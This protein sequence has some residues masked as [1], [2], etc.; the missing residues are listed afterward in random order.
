MSFLRPLPYQ[1]LL[2]EIGL[3]L[4]PGVQAYLVGGAVRDAILGRPTNDLDFSVSQNAIGLGRRVA[5]NLDGA[6]YALD[7]DRD[8]A[9]VI[10]YEPDG[11]RQILDFAGLRGVDINSDL[12]GRDFTLNAMALDLH[13]PP[14]LLDPLDG[15]NDMRSGLLRACSERAIVDDPLRILRGV[16]LASAY[17]LRIVP[18]TTQL[19]RQAVHLLPRVSVERVRDELVRTLNGPRQAVSL[20]LLDAFGVLPDILPEIANLK[21]VEQSPPHINDV[22]VHTVDVISKL[23]RV[24]S[25]LSLHH[26]PEVAAN[27]ALGF[28]SV[29]LGRYREQIYDQLN[30]SITTG[31]SQRSL[32]FMAALYHDTGKP[33]TFQ[34]DDSGRIRFFKHE[35]IGSKLVASRG[36][37]LRLSKDEVKYLENIVRNH[38]RPL[39]LTK[40]GNPPSRRAIYRF[41]R[42]TGQAGVDVCL[43]SLADTLATYG[44]KLPAELW[45]DQLS[46]VRNLLE[47]WFE[48]QEEA[49]APT[50]IIN[51]GDLIEHFGIAPGP[52]IGEL[53]NAIREAQATGQVTDRELALDFAKSWLETNGDIYGK[54]SS[55]EGV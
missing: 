23:E 35:V 32:L 10:L 27:W 3:I 26:D 46:V 31:R 1:D 44:P 41:F 18:E 45:A 17:D 49:V 9:R 37:F 25:V 4:P 28:I 7:T 51:G 34:I 48:R 12:L 6:F 43:L 20:R 40:A 15:S 11:S 33:E 29:Q 53:L 14:K 5:D 47:S 52:Q 8:T 38:M 16:R 36:H 39:S 24:L 55:K 21:G 50:A 42:D 22:W 54:S 19:M 13:G 2:N 30:D